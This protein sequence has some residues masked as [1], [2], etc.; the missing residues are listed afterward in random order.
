MTKIEKIQNLHWKWNGKLEPIGKMHNNKLEFIRNF[1]MTNR[2]NFGTMSSEEWSE[3]IKYLIDYR[4]I[5]NKHYNIVE[6][7]SL[8]IT[9]KMS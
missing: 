6:K 9:N 4:K 7:V 5:K 1:V 3:N 2:G 8:I